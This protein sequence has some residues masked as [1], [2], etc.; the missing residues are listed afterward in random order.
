[1]RSSAISTRRAGQEALRF[2]FLLVL[3]VIL[4]TVFEGAV[5]KWIAPGLTS[6]L[7]LCRDCAAF[8]LVA[9]TALSGR[10]A[11][12]PFATQCLLAWTFVVAGWGL[13]QI[14][15]LQGP[16]V[17]FLLGLRF[18]LLY[19]WMALAMACTL[20]N[21]EIVRV[22]RLMIVLGIM[23]T[24]LVM[25]Q[26]VL[27][28]SSPINVQPDTDE[29]AIFRVTADIVR[30]SGTFTF[31]MGFA[32]FIAVVSPIAISSVWN[33]VRL[34][35][36][37]WLAVVAFIAVSIS[38]LVSGSRASIMFFGALLAVQT[39]AGLGAAK[40]G[41]ALMQSFVRTALAVIAL[42]VTLGVFSDALTATQERFQTAAADEDVMGRIE[43]E[44]LG[45]PA[46]RKEMNAIGHGLGAGTNAGSVLLTGENAFEL[47]ESE[48][49]RVLLEM[50]VIGFAWL[51]VKCL[52][53]AVGL[54]RSLV[55]LVRCSETL[56][57]LMWATT[58]YG[59]SSWPVSGQVSAN[60]FGYIALGLALCSTRTLPASAPIDD[61]MLNWGARS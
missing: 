1:M 10:F 42:A 14:I 59:M 43:T 3:T 35:R 24:P 36:H 54:S 52:I 8:A 51:M 21:Q 57:L 33:G 48:P 2:D 23:M 39:L 41:K 15:V 55:R 30:V 27:P 9:R 46:A 53:F 22:M 56:P 58:A 11:A 49:A 38:T 28:P 12:M 19:F 20:T 29:D 16:I 61:P 13:F 25:L 60:A 50:G 40:T 18:W 26:H 47:A 17:L 32:C 45:E 5:R 31:T 7:L 6:P 34:Y 37:A 4:V 44:L